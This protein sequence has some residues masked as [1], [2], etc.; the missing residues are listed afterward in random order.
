MTAGRV[1]HP[2]KEETKAECSDPTC[3]WTFTTIVPGMA[4]KA[5]MA[6]NAEEHQ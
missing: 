1:Y 2:T 3:P 6:H 4:A 5:L